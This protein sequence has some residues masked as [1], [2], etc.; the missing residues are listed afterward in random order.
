MDKNSVAEALRALAG[1]EGRSE[2]ARL[3]D[4]FGE[5]EAALAAGVSRSA[6]LQTLHEQGFTM[7]AKS[8]ESALYRLRKQRAA[9]QLGKPNAARVHASIPARTPAAAPQ[10]LTPKEGD[11]TPPAEEEDLSLLSPKERRERR[12]DQFI[13]TEA[14]S[15][16]P[17]LKSILKKDQSK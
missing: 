10:V 13:K 14:Q 12:A 8:F 11:D 9:G 17:L 7:T 3:R 5:V 1:G 15:T 16:N 2:T 4:V 6:I